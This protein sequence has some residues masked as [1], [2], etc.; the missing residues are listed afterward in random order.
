MKF[1][2]FN[3][4]NI[5]GTC[6]EISLGILKAFVLWTQMD[7]MS[8]IARLINGA[9][10]FYINIDGLPSTV[11]FLSLSAFVLISWP[12]ICI[13]SI[14]TVFLPHFIGPMPPTVHLCSQFVLYTSFIDRLPSRCENSNWTIESKNVFMKR[15]LSQRF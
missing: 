15:K 1:F 9:I 8:S 10:C 11:H 2:F 3:T 7:S 14:L 13:L 12:N 4:K 6:Q 5:S